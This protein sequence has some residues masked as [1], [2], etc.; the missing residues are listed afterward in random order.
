MRERRPGSVGA[1]RSAPT[2]PDERPRRAA[3]PDR[4]RHQ[5]RGAAGAGGARR[6]G[7]GRQDHLDGHATWASCSP[8]GWTTSSEQLSPTT[9]REYRRLVRTMIDPDLGQ[10]PAAAS[11][12]PA[13]RRLLRQPGS[14]AR[15]LAGIDPTRP[16][17]PAGF[18]RPG[19]AVG[20]DP[21]ERGGQRLAAQTPPARDHAAAHARR[22]HTVGG[23]R[24]R[25]TPI[26]ALLRVLVATGARRGEV[27][28]LRW[29]DVDATGSTVIIRRSVASVAG[30]TVVKDTKTHAARR[31]AVDAETFGL[32]GTARSVR[33]SSPRR[34][35]SLFDP[36]GFVFT[37]K[38]DGSR[39]LH[40]D[41]ITG[42][43]QRLCERPGSMASGCTTFATSTPP[44]Y[45]PPAS[46]Y[47]PSAAARPR[48]RRDHVER[49]RPLP[50]GQ[51]PPSGRCDRRA[52]G[53]VVPTCRALADGVP[54]ARVGP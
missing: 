23:R 19:G 47:E 39:P 32:A 12:H 22:S 16:R 6:R 26:S 27:C 48:Q 51:R 10:A 41:T 25:T 50:R 52:P 37:S 53:H 11:H 29:T 15:A 28:G 8:A 7:L 5:A 49:L 38:P 40:P 42:G 45:S 9:V 2:G 17:R 14:R 54:A 21:V 20:L 44:S 36:H 24:Q 13:H 34:A 43:F 4:A 30:G 3:E 35:D 18:A 1:H 46:R 33:R 31:I